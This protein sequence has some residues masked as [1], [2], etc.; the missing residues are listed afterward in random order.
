MTSTLAPDEATPR[1]ASAAALLLVVGLT[2][3][4]VAG[5]KAVSGD[6]PPNGSGSSVPAIDYHG[7]PYNLQTG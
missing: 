7:F 2:G 4:A 5:P 3:C 1:R 6:N